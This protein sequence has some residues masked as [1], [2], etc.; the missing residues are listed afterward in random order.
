MLFVLQKT[1]YMKSNLGAQVF[2]SDLGDSFGDNVTAS[3]K[4]NIV[5]LLAFAN[6][7]TYSFYVLSPT[8]YESAF[9]SM[10]LYI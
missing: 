3:Y 1:L 7:G 8:R 6:L 9:V 4:A 2:Q 10:A 5:F